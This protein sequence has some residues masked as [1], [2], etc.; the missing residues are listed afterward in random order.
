MEKGYGT[1]K[2]SVL[3]FLASACTMVLE[4]IAGRILAPYIGVSLYT[5]TSIIG[6]VLTGIA[7]GNYLGGRLGDRYGSP[8]MVTCIFLGG[9]LTSLAILPE[10]LILNN[11]PLPYEFHLMTKTTLYT[12]MLFFLPTCILGM[13]TPVV[14]R[15]NLANIARTGRTVGTIYAI[16][17][18]GAI[19]G[20]FATGFV[21]IASFGT[22]SILWG[23]AV[24][25][26]L[27]GI[28]ASAS[29]HKI[30]K[31][32]LSVFVIV[33]YLA[34]FTWRDNFAAPVLKESNYFSINIQDTTIQGK[35]VK[36]L[37]LD[38]LIHSYIDLNDPTFLGYDYEKVF[39]QLTAYKAGAK[40]N[41]RALFIGGGG[42][43]F[44]R[45]LEVIY[46]SSEIDVVEIDP[47]VT[48][49]VYD[50]LAL[51]RDTRIK[52]INSDARIFFIENRPTAKYDL[53][54]GDAFNDMSVPF[55]LTTYEFN[56]LIKR[57]M[58]PDGI[59]M[60][61]VIDDLTQGRFL[62]SLMKTL[63][64]SFE[65]VYLF[66]PD[67]A[68]DSRGAGTYVAAA[69]VQPI[70]MNRFASVVLANDLD[71]AN[72]QMVRFEELPAAI[73]VSEAV[74]LSDNYV[75]VDNMVAPLFIH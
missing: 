59:Y 39:A 62:A 46:P 73:P 38:R 33:A 75:P 45:Y 25:L 11:S 64:E 28:F 4:L 57:S 70:D 29:W 9:G 37:S 66:L 51:S 40:P 67:G 14:I 68:L 26:L 48:E 19:L 50:Y 42:Y 16:S 47:A 13:V 52:T 22:R 43:S 8:L 74:F 24:L 2:A 53:V 60:V 63:R 12:L 41:F 10:T 65:Y 18:F 35:T 54:M 34:A 27:T 69:A 20:T 6:V 61:N 44:S 58:R 1:L 72:G 55:H 31:W 36:Y 32:G 30:I 21:L 49:V 56:E 15:L 7:L 23:V 5:W 17:T 3:V 71:L